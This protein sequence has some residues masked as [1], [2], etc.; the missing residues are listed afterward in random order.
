MEGNYFLI[1]FVVWPMAAAIIAFFSGKGKSKFKNAFTQAAV[2]IELIIAL[3]LLFGMN[4]FVN[5]TFIWKGFAERGIRLEIS[6]FRLTLCILCCGVWVISALCKRD[7]KPSKQ[8]GTMEFFLLVT[9]G[10]VMGL[11]LSADL[12]TLF[13]CFEVLSLS[14]YVMVVGNERDKEIWALKSYMAYGIIGGMVLLMGLLLLDEAAGTLE[15]QRLLEASIQTEHTQVL[16]AAGVCMFL[17]F[18]T[19]A[20]IFPLHTWLASCT[21]EASPSAGMIISAVWTKTGLFGI[22]ILCGEIFLGNRSF[23]QMLIVFGILTMLLGSVRSLFVVNLNRFTAY[24]AI[25]QNGFLLITMGAISQRGIYGSDVQDGILL[26]M[27]LYTL[28]LVLLYMAPNVPAYLLAG[29]V[30][31]LLPLL[32]PFVLK[33]MADMNIVWVMIAVSSVLMAAGHFRAVGILRRDNRDDSMDKPKDV[34]PRYL[35]L[36]KSLYDPFLFKLLPFLCAIVFRALDRLVDTI[37]L[38]LH[39]T[40]YRPRKKK[41]SLEFGTRTTHTLGSM[42]DVVVYILNHTILR[43]RPIRMSFVE[44]LAVTKEEMSQTTRLV[45]RSLSFSLL[46]FCIGLIVILIYLLGG[47]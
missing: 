38:L 2:A 21:E 18:A 32:S 24:T 46:L 23:G 13:I 42:A 8:C 5:D 22:L 41:K 4:G 34:W 11:F 40:L 45:S 3:C 44:A 28:V 37:V 33:V 9:L 14:S 36:E 30:N 29:I 6:A 1:L 12:F 10:A 31:V 15:I 20:A 16:F 26:Y 47:I 17:G 27:V 7:L 43:R 19:K 39:K 35:D 25:F